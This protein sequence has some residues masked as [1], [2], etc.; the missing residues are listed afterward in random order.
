MTRSL[1]RAA[2]RRRGRLHVVEL[3]PEP[4]P[5]VVDLARDILRRT[6]SGEIVALGICAV[7]SDGCTANAW[8]HG[9][10]WAQ[11][12]GASCSLRAGLEGVT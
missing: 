7:T 10:H 4:V 2:L 9:N 6:E 5:D 12:L 11:L 8:H 1:T 3:K